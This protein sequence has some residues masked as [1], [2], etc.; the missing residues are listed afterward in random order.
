MASEERL[1]TEKTKFVN[2]TTVIMSTHVEQAGSSREDYAIGQFG[3]KSELEVCD[4]RSR[5][6]CSFEQ[7]RFGLWSMIGISCTI[8]AMWEGILLLVR[9]SPNTRW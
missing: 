4:A 7:R 5:D 2:S 1:E 9:R 8:M 6:F 3:Y